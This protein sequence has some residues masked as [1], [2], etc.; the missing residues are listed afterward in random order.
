MYRDWGHDAEDGWFGNWQPNQPWSMDIPAIDSWWLPATSS[1]FI[2]DVTPG[3]VIP[4]KVGKG[5]KAMAGT[6]DARCPSLIPKD[7]VAGKNGSIKI[8][9]IG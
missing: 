8:K 9:V 4:Y 7:G 3:M 1:S 2:A 6:W 5:G